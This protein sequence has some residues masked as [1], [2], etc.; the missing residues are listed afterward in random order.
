[1]DVVDPDA[2]RPDELIQCRL[3]SSDFKPGDRMIDHQHSVRAAIDDRDPV[4][5]RCPACLRH[6]LSSFP[7]CT[8][9]CRLRP[10]VILIRFFRQISIRILLLQNFDGLSYDLLPRQLSL[11]EQHAVNRLKHNAIVMNILKLAECIPGRMILPLL[12]GQ[13]LPDLL[14]GCLGCRQGVISIPHRH[15]EFLPFAEALRRLVIEP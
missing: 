7:V 15:E 13:C 14:P 1:M 12:R 11:T 9:S 6:A 8:A 2:F 5:V 10:R 4:A 3:E